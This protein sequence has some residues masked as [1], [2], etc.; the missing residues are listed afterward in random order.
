MVL[1]V[2]AGTR[3]RTNTSKRNDWIQVLY[4]PPSAEEYAKQR[5]LKWTREGEIPGNQLPRP[6][7]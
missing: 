1:E 6:E 3:E 4:L 7:A 5:G 2:E